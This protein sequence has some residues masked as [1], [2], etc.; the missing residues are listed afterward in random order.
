VRRPGRLEPLSESRFKVEFTATAALR[1]KLERARDLMSHANPSRE[2]ANVVESA[3]DL[4]LEKL[5]S[6]RLGKLKRAPRKASS[7]GKQSPERV[8]RDVRR[9]VFARDGEQCTFV[10][11]D[12]HRC[13]ARSFLELDHIDPLGL[14][15]ASDVAN[16]RVRCRSHNQLWAEQVFGREHVAARRDFHRRKSSAA[17]A[18]QLRAKTAGDAQGL[19]HQG[20]ALLES[21]KALDKVRLALK[22]LGFRDAEARRAVAE[23]QC[24]TSFDGAAPGFEQLLREA[25]RRVPLGEPC[26]R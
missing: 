17:P 4:L 7:R 21:G 26:Q 20:A 10:G 5:E 9:Q 1:E 12:G 23:L 19:D 16:I 14:G 3:L 18:G 6:R 25:L 15:G 11:P 13:S 24:S 8:S 22:R 2:I